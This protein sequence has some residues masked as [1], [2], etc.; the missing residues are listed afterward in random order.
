M[1]VL[2]EL[3]ELLD[4]EPRQVVSVIAETLEQ[5][6]DDLGGCRGDRLF[7]ERPEAHHVGVIL[8]RLLEGRQIARRPTAR[9][10]DLRIGI[11][12]NAGAPIGGPRRTAPE[13]SHDEQEPRSPELF[14]DRG[15]GTHPIVVEPPGETVHRLRADVDRAVVVVD[16]NVFVITIHFFPSSLVLS[17]PS[18]VL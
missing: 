17:L 18:D 9:P 13:V 14:A 2:E 10:Q 7:G 8:G 1:R 11:V 3:D 15:D 4:R 6:V 5:I 16:Q 12:P